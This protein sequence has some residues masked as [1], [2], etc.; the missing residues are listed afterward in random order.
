MTKESAVELTPV[1]VNEQFRTGSWLS[2]YLWWAGLK[3][4]CCEAWYRPDKRAI[5]LSVYVHLEHDMGD[6]WGKSVFNLGWGVLVPFEFYTVERPV[7][8]LFILNKLALDAM[9]AWAL[10]TRSMDGY[11][12]SE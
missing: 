4:R 2:N 3:Y 10:R 5:D 6:S 9:I 7:L 1:I 8:E 12:V 11:I